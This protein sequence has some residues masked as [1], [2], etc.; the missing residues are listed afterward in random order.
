MRSKCVA[1]A[2]QTAA[3]PDPGERSVIICAVREPGGTKQWRRMFV[4][5][6]DVGPEQ[7]SSWISLPP[8]VFGA[9]VPAALSLNLSFLAPWCVH[10][11]VIF[12]F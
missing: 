7:G 10:F 8:R 3:A 2:T 5:R 1:R 6:K 12:W 4:R 11:Y 9:F